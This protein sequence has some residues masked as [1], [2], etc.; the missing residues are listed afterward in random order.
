MNIATIEHWVLKSMTEAQDS[1]QNGE[2]PVG[3]C[4]LFDMKYLMIFSKPKEKSVKKMQYSIEKAR[5]V[6][7][8]TKRPVGKKETLTIHLL[9]KNSRTIIPVQNHL[10]GKNKTLK[11]RMKT[12]KTNLS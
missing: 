5:N 9:L 8:T 12:P 2:V 3:C 10:I 7:L 11:I 6:N 1:L 4:S